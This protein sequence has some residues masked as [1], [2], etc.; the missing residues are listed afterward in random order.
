MMAMPY[1][2]IGTDKDPRQVIAP[3]CEQGNHQTCS[4]KP[5][6]VPFGD[7]TRVARCVCACHGDQAR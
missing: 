2:G 6:E 4:P 5:F 7:V 1:V 3:R